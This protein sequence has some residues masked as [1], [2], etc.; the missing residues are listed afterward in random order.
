MP[1]TYSD[2]S[3]TLRAN[4]MC[5]VQNSGHVI[6]VMTVS[7]NVSLVFMYN[8]QMQSQYA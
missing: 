3:D 2:V 8:L 7:L 1:H 5:V 6:G 4:K